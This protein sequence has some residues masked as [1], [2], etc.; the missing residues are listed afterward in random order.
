[1]LPTVLRRPLAEKIGFAAAHHWPRILA[2]SHDDIIDEISCLF[3]GW[4]RDEFETIRS[5]YP[6]QHYADRVTQVFCNSVNA[7]EICNLLAREPVGQKIIFTGGGLL[8]NPLSANPQLEF[9]H[10][11]PGFLP[12]VKGADGILW[13]MLIRGKIGASIISMDAGLDTGDVLFQKE[14][15][16]PAITYTRDEIDGETLYRIIYSFLDPVCRSV[17]LEQ[18][19]SENINLTWTK[20][21]QKN[22]VGLLCHFMHKRIRTRIL[23]RIF[24]KN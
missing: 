3:P 6:L 20:M 13:S 12:H 9:L 7:Y 23:K 24:K 2:N 10:V 18:F 14:W 5:P 16:I 1:M 21:P 4:G 15:Q 11:H 17:I 22:N 8:K 19:L